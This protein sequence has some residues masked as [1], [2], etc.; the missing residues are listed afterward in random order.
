MVVL[1]AVRRRSEKFE[2][3]KSDVR[4]QQNK[5]VWPVR[6]VSAALRRFA[7]RAISAASRPTI[8]LQCMYGTTTENRSTRVDRIQRSLPTRYEH[9]RPRSH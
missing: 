3:R 6:V 1:M 2:V 9:V 8:Y 7:T 4:S 5:R